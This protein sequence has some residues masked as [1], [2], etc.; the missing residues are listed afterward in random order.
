MTALHSNC[1]AILAESASFILDR[2]LHRTS[3]SC[4]GNQHVRLLRL[5]VHFGYSI[6]RANFIIQLFSN[7]LCPL[8][9]NRRPTL[10][11]LR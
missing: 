10:H 6:I 8:R 1:I 7:K 11:V 2:Y 4:K 3:Y 9:L 5:C